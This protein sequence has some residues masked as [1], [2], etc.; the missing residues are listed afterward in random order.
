MVFPVRTRRLFPPD[1]LSQLN[2]GAQSS[3]L[4]T[5]PAY[6]YS[7]RLDPLGG[8]TEFFFFFGPSGLAG[9]REKF[10]LYPSP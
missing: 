4:L 10:P 2:S 6:V 1:W 5:N 7:S 8:P 3:F 9:N